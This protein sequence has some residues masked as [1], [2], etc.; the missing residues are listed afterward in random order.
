MSAS[1]YI[2]DTAF[3]ALVERLHGI[4]NRADGVDRWEI[5]LALGEHGLLPERTAEPA[6][7]DSLVASLRAICRSNLGRRDAA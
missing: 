6:M 1:T 7:E 2:T 4:A 5:R 3:E